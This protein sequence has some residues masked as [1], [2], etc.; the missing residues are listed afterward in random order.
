MNLKQQYRDFCS[1]QGDIPL[2]LQDWWLDVVCS[3][4]DVAIVMNGDQVSGIWPY[5][6]EQKAGVTLHRNP[7]LTPYLGPYVFYPHD[8][9]DS[10]RDNF[11]HE[12]VAELLSQIRATKVWWLALLPNQKQVGLYNASGFD[13]QPRQ[14]F[15]MPLQDTEEEIF[16]RLHEDYRRNI[17]K[18]ESEM[19]IEHDPGLLPSLWQYQ[20]ATLDRKDVNMHFSVE[21]LQKLFDACLQRNC[22]ALWVA[23]KAGEVQAILWHI[24]DGVRAYYLVGSKNP[25]TKDNRA[26][27]ALI[28]KA[29]SESKKMGKYSFDFEG[30]M[31]PGVE[32]FFRNFGAE[33]TLYLVLQKNDS[34]LWKLKEKIKG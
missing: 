34:L 33:R 1:K 5:P 15:I 11:E 3:D 23:K 14:T 27:T 28:W 18:A 13:I 7:A 4:W 29:I 6:I 31:D 19:T 25:A 30:S 24:W 9:K 2:F 22:T 20:K 8:L 16:S 10:K 26:M 17:R 12:V 32:K 21:Q